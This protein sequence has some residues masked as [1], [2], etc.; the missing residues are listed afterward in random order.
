MTF[1]PQIVAAVL[2][3]DPSPL[4]SPVPGVWVH[5]YPASL[6]TG[7]DPGKGRS[8]KPPSPRKATEKSKRQGEES[9]E[10]GVTV[11]MT[12]LTPEDDSNPQLK[13]GVYTAPKWSYCHSVT[14]GLRAYRKQQGS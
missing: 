13:K 3:L 6:V 14:K 4:P 11:T 8:A 2:F 1:P 7:E 12:R 9:E 10:E 5:R